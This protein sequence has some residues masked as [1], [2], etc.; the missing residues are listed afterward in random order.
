MI[1]VG[2]G[3]SSLLSA[4]INQRFL[5]GKMDFRCIEP[6]PR[7]FLKTGFDG[8]TELIVSPVEAVPIGIFES[9]QASDVLFIDSSH[10][11]KTGSDVNYL[12]LE[13]L[14]RLNP[15]VVIHIHDV[16]LPGEYPEEW[17]L[18]HRR[19][20]NEQYLVQ[21]LLIH[22]SGFE[23]LFSCSYAFSRFRDSVRDALALNDD[24]VFGGCSLWI[25][26]KAL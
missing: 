23:V 17:V 4:D 24:R 15:G 22:S 2:S 10:V 19:S 5:G 21:A 1:E 12:L 18:K 16:F 13:I 11:S 9:L 20:W 7:K 3:Y 8:L 6:Y 25:R 26:R 14:P